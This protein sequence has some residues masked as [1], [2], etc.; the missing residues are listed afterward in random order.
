[1]VAIIRQVNSQQSFAQN[2]NEV[3]IKCKTYVQ[4]NE[5]KM[6]IQILISRNVDSKKK[7]ENALKT[8]R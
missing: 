3:R 4:F 6:F 7:N 2:D 5:K 1:M 8:G